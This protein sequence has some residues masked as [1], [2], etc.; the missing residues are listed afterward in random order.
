MKKNN[1]FTGSFLATWILSMAVAFSSCS[2]DSD[3][4]GSDILPQKDNNTTAQADEEAVAPFSLV[5]KAF[6]GGKEVTTNGDVES[7]T[8]FIFDDNYDFIKQID[9]DKS[10]L[11][12]RKTI[13]IHAQN[14]D[15]ITVVAWGGL[16][17]NKE[18]VS[19]L[20]QNSVLADL[21]VQLKQSNGQIATSPGDLFYGKI[22][23]QRPTTTKAT[24]TQTLSI[25]RKV[26]SVTLTSVNIV[27]KFG[28]T[29]GDFYYKVKSKNNAINFNGEVQGSDVEYIVPVYVNEAG[30]LSTETIAVLPSDEIEIELYRDDIMVA[31]SKN[32]KTTEN[33]SVNEGKQLAVNFDMTRLISSIH[34]ADWGT[35]INYVSFS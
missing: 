17:N 7:T 14:A 27:K 4:I 21:R 19:T 34:V 33:L 26:S 30:N 8:L 12:Q 31:S 29:N 6:S 16:T 15:R 10:T 9:V 23:L 20:N 13:Q 32:F 18:E 24:E 5:L 3:P 35:V 25:E 11:L 1:I 2:S 22:T 28:T